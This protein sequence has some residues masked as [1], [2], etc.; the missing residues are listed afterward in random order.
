M[1]FG[2]WDFF[3]E[4]DC[5]LISF[6]SGLGRGFT[7][8]AG[9]VLGFGIWDLG[10]LPGTGLLPH[11]IRK[12]PWEGLHKESRY[13]FGIWDLGFGISS[14]N[15][16]ASSFHSEAALGGASQ[17]KPLTSPRRGI[18]FFPCSQ[19]QTSLACSQRKKPTTFV[20]GFLCSGNWTRTSD[21]RVMSPTSYL[22]L[23]PAIW[24]AKIQRIVG[25]IKTCRE[26]IF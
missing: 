7:K 15:W 19:A 3:P 4:L 17:R 9:T 6:G 10:F 25:L 21:L 5:F 22:L 12:R 16:I 13:C 8:K 26:N 14:R 18:G 11:F 1:G 23:Y 2:I 20:D 24:K